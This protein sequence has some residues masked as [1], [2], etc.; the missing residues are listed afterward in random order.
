MYGKFTELVRK[1]RPLAIHMCTHI[2][3]ANVAVAAHAHR[4]KASPS[5]AFPP[6]TRPRAC[7][8]I[9]AWL[10]RLPGA[11]AVAS[12]IPARNAPLFG[13]ETAGNA[14]S[15]DASVMP[16][17]VTRRFC[18]AIRSGDFRQMLGKR[19]TRSLRTCND[20]GISI[21]V[22]ARAWRSSLIKA[23]PQSGGATHPPGAMRAG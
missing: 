15:A 13:Y 10:K 6:T 9:C 2:T 17:Y 7:G 3:A 11:A 12:G 19:H 1:R 21:C 4:D 18:P 22:I 16:A 23:S 8:R 14:C 5:C 20:L